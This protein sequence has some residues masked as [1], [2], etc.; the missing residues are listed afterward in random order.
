MQC[1]RGW[2]LGCIVDASGFAAGAAYQSPVIRFYGYNIIARNPFGR[3]IEPMFEQNDFRRS[4]EPRGEFPRLSEAH[5]RA[6]GR[7]AEMVLEANRRFNLTAITDSAEMAVKHYLDALSCCLAVDF[8]KVEIVCDVGSGAGFPAM[9]LAILF[10]Q[11]SF[12]LLE[13]NQKKASFLLTAMEGLCLSN[14]RVIADRAENVGRGE[15]RE[16]FQV[17]VSRGV[18]PLPVLVEYCLPLVRIGGVFLAM[19]GQKGEEEAAG[20]KGVFPLLGAEGAESLRIRLGEAGERVLVAA[21]KSKKTPEKYPRRPG[22]P[23]KR[24]LV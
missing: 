10:P 20:C 17:V 4:G 15:M 5:L 22:I 1:G 2:A 13:S 9:P 12:T 6:F 14:C 24:P 21:H 19:R 11:V 8:S 7:H 3:M 23:Q 16:T 18:A